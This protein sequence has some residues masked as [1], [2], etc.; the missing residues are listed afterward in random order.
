MSA[1][2]ARGCFGGTGGPTQKR[3]SA[4]RAQGCSA[5]NSLAVQPGAVISP[6][7]G[8]LPSDRA[9]H[10]ERGG[11]VPVHGDAPF[12]ATAS[13]SSTCHLPY[14]GC[15]HHFPHV[16][17]FVVSRLPRTRDAPWM[18]A[19]RRAVRSSA[20]RSCTRSRTDGCWRVTS[21]CTGCSVLQ[22]VGRVAYPVTSPC[23]GCCGVHWALRDP[24]DVASPHA[25]VLPRARS[26]HR[27]S[28]GRLPVRGSASRQAHRQATHRQPAPRAR[29]CSA[30]LNSQSTLWGVTSPCAGALHRPPRPVAHRGV[31]IPIRDTNEPPPPCPPAQGAS[32]S[33]P[34]AIGF[35]SHNRHPRPPPRSPGRH[36]G[37]LWL[38]S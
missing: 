9:D 4:P 22:I 10:P 19:L 37:N 3:R 8:V 30:C 25:G 28:Y 17:Y 27:R 15:F 35:V 38:T 21:P 33:I 20:P 23:T 32:S 11:D 5:A 24:V 12:R 6:Y 7:A 16:H 31:R 1:P 34:D 36:P 13:A 29:G 26:G 2:R 18:D 14:A